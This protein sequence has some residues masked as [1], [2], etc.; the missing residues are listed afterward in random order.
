M[1]LLAVH[2]LFTK[3]DRIVGPKCPKRGQMLHYKNKI[4]RMIGSG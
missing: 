1:L 2:R 4:R 3:E